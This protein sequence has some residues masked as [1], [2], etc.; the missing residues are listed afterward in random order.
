M[1]RLGLAVSIRHVSHVCR[2]GPACALR[3]FK[4]GKLTEEARI[5]PEQVGRRNL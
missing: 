2:T 4:P 5:M 3:N 1:I